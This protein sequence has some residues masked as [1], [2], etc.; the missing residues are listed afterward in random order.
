MKGKI[1]TIL[2]CVFLLV[3]AIIIL[4]SVIIGGVNVFNFLK[5]IVLALG[6]GNVFL[7]ILLTILSGFGIFNAFM[8]VFHPPELLENLL[9]DAPQWLSNIYV[10]LSWF[11][12]LSLLLLFA[13]AAQ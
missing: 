5:N 10:A 3:I 1:G 2:C 7:G 12:T 11:G 8:G 9:A 13:I 6:N 4:L